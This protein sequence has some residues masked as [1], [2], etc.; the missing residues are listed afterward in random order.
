MNKSSLYEKIMLVFSLVLAI[1]VVVAFSIPAISMTMSSGSQEVTTG[2]Y[3]F[4]STASSDSSGTMVP[5]FDAFASILVC[6]I[7]IV[8]PFVALLAKN[9]A[10]KCVG[11]AMI[12]TGCAWSF[13]I[14]GYYAPAIDTINEAI[15][16]AGVDM[17]FSTPALTLVIVES[18]LALLFVLAIIAHECFGEV[19]AKQ[20][21]NM[22]AAASN[23]ANTPAQKL[24]SLKKMK[25][26]GLITDEEY[27]AK[28]KAILDEIA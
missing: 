26:S 20:I 8:G 6:I 18:V 7:A 3:F 16:T 24:E 28:R 27:E 21:A 1:F 12:L 10:G 22:K 4:S 15:E 14:N 25:E 2:I 9:M 5:A 13:A 19:I 11:L 17:A 23:S